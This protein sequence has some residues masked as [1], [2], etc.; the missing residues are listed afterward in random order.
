MGLSTEIKIDQLRDSTVDAAP[1]ELPPGTVHLWQR[2]LQESS[3][4]VEACY[5]LLSA[6]EREKALR[7][8][9]ERPRSDFVLTRGTLRLLLAAYLGTTP[10]EVSFEYS[11]YGKPRLAVS[12][13]VRFN[14]SHTNGLALLGFARN[15]EIGIDVEQMRAEVEVLKL[16]RR[17]FS[18]HEI[19]EIEKRSGDKLR[20][21]FFH[22][23]TRKEAYIKARGEGL[24][25][26]LQE[27]DVSVDRG[28][29]QALLATRPDA[30]EASRWL[31]RD[32]PL[33]NG[34]AGA[35]SVGEEVRA[36]GERV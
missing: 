25:L 33:S 32:V 35:L 14:V 11:E 36:L 8:R 3:E 15:R 28:A 13:D 29:T 23:W 6:E 24:S 27:F 16:A 9:I 2:S 31:I 22:C 5:Q 10:R 34:Y 18:T 19:D 7:Y 17:F 21:A 30:S 4:A 12:C 20:R 1:S 26:P